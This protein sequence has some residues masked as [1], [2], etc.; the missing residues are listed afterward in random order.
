MSYIR[1][2][3]SALKDRRMWEQISDGCYCHLSPP[4]HIC[5]HPGNPLNQD[6]DEC[7]IELGGKVAA[8]R[9]QREGKYAG[10]TAANH[11]VHGRKFKIKRQHFRGRELTAFGGAL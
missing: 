7:W 9:N 10:R 11:D 8:S 1:L 6:S 5:M 4:C 2:T 3:L